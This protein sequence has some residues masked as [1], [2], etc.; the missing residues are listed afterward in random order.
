MSSYKEVVS[1]QGAQWNLQQE[2]DGHL[3]ASQQLRQKNI[4][5]QGDVR[6]IDNKI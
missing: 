4:R 5:T 1:S 6:T 2:S 3:A